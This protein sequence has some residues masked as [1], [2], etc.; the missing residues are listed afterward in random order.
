MRAKPCN[1]NIA[2]KYML[3]VSTRYAHET[4]KGERIF[5]KYVQTIDISHAREALK[6]ET[7]LQIHAKLNTSHAREYL[8]CEKRYDMHT[9]NR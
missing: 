6:C 9:E 4:L 8:K 5:M 1:A 7:R 3:K 2:I